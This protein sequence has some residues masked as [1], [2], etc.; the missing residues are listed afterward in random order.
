MNESLLREFMDEDCDQDARRELLAAIQ[1]SKF[2]P[3]RVK[4]SYTFNRFKVT[5]DFHA[6]QVLIEDDPTVGQ[7][8]EYTLRLEA[9]ADFLCKQE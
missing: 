3:E 9:F 2:Q 6:G 8:G 7:E 4:R 1:E 5:L